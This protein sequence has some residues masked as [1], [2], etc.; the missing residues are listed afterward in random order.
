MHGISVKQA[1]YQIER[2]KDREEN[3]RGRGEESKTLKRLR[4]E[5]ANA[6]FD[7]AG[8]FW[9]AELL[10]QIGGIVLVF[11]LICLGATAVGPERWLAMVML[12]IITFSLFVA[13]VS[14]L[15]SIVSMSN[16]R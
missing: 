12:G 9:M 4:K 16:I 11:G 15:M 5:A 14:S 3:D 7:A 6:R 13:N 10:F 2:N 8:T 1:D